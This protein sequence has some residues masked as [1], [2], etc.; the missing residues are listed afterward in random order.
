MKY[1]D[2]E[3][4]DRRGHKMHECSERGTGSAAPGSPA[5]RKPTL[6]L[7]GLRTKQPGLESGQGRAKERLSDA[8]AQLFAVENTLISWGAQRVGVGAIGE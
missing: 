5:V 4:D 6:E 2:S 8:K 7:Q 3:T 1:E